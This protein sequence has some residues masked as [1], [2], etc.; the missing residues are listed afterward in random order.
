MIRIKV[1]LLGTPKT[2][3]NGHLVT[4]PFKKAEALFYYLMVRKQAT[5]DEL[6]NL[7]WAELDENVAKKNLRNAIYMLRRV[8]EEEIVRSPQRSIVVLNEEISWEIDIEQFF[9]NDEI[10]S[11]DA[12]QGEFL[13]G[14]LVKDAENFEQ[15]MFQSRESYRDMYI[16]KLHRAIKKH[17]STNKLTEAEAYCKLLI[18]ADE[19]DEEAYRSLMKIY[20]M[21][22]FFNKGIETYNR[23]VEVLNRELSIP[24]DAKTEEAFDAL[25]KEKNLRENIKEYE[26][27][28]FFYG[29]GK[30]LNILNQN[31]KRFIEGKNGTSI[32]I[33]GEAGIGKTKLMEQFIM[34]SNDKLPIFT[35]YCYEAEER[36]LLKPWNGIFQS[37]SKYIN[38]YSI[39]IPSLWRNIVGYIFPMFDIHSKAADINPVEKIDILKFQVAEKTIVSILKTVAERAKIIIHIEDL[40][41]A[42]DISLSLL[43][44][45]LQEAQ[46]ESIIII[47]TCRDAYAHKVE[48]FLSDMICY[49]LLR[50]LEVGRFNRSEV[51]EFAE[52][53][54]SQSIPEE[55]KE[56]IYNETEGNT[57]F[58][59]EYLNNIKHNL[60]MDTITPKMKDILK[61]RILNVSEEGQ[62]ILNIASIYFDKVYYQSL[63]ELS[64]KNELELMDIM[65]ELRNKR[66]IKEVVLGNEVGFVFTHQKLREYIYN[67]L[68]HSRR[69]ILHNRAAVILEGSLK[70]K[71]SD[72]ELYSK[73]IYHFVNGGN[74]LAALKYSIKN[75]EECLHFSH[76]IFPVL[77]STGLKQS[78]YLY[79]K[80]EEALRQLK[81]LNILLQ[82]VKEEAE[83]GQ[84]T[85]DELELLYLLMIGR[86]HITQGEYGKGLDIIREI[87][88]KAV[89]T[90][91]WGYV[92]K[93]YRQLIYYCINTQNTGEMGEYLS[94]ALEITEISGEKG[95]MAILLRLK[96]Y[97]KIMEAKYDEAESLLEQAIFVFKMLNDH[98]YYVLNIAACYNFIGESKR[99]QCKFDEAIEYYSKAITICEESSVLRGVTIFYTNA[100]QAAFD[101]G[102][103]EGA[104]F[105]LKKSLGYYSQLDFLWG[106]STAKAYTALLS[107]EEKRYESALKQ[108]IDAETDAKKLKSPY[109]LGLVLKA[110]AEI[111]ALMD[112][113]PR[114]NKIFEGYLERDIKEYCNEAINMFKDLQGCYEVERLKQL[115][116][117]NKN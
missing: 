109:E 67:E 79:L 54:L 8:F 38:K 56:I 65:D 12:Y 16:Q 98:N 74:K 21:Q 104:R 102:D 33:L 9:N 89:E 19:L 72:R 4:F 37:L 103:Y 2:I 96:G 36:Y 20:G 112:K 85:I 17:F 46:N 28:E 95:E 71:K 83:E 99:H 48:R 25:L 90:N 88:P 84:D 1:L 43:R 75:L 11:I 60:H 15:W 81:E 107:I 86:F 32:I 101:K 70:N 34:R 105:F 10:G 22:E 31:Y 73:L 117:T 92:L 42:D 45:I 26:A 23:L 110:K 115:R 57:F 18:K 39:E 47:A 80:P 41:W 24:P 14:L 30:E 64:G 87:I 35:G 69:R 62:K 78:Q 97:L 50:K 3:Y 49:G 93:G 111:R 91:N 66:L 7:L 6:V 63:Y 13:H 29:R 77:S 82:E 68:S 100:G 27:D 61:N 59:V 116:K 53:L 40:Q 52:A 114:L 113:I 94:K 55:Q 51:Y 76:E 106:R 5:R 58:L 108:L 44:T